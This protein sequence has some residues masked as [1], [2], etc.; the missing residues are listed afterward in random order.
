MRTL[1]VKNW[2]SF[3]HYKDRSPP[4]IRLYNALLDDYEFG[5]L[6]DASKWHLVAIW[7][8][9]SRSDN[10]IPYDAGW[11]SRR[12]NASKTVDLDALINSRF[13][14]VNQEEQ[15]SEHDASAPL[16]SCSPEQSR[17]EQSRGR[18][19]TGPAAIDPNWRP[20]AQTTTALLAEGFSASKLELSRT[21]MI[22]WAISNGKRKHDWDA[23]LRN[24][25]RRKPMETG[26][27]RQDRQ[28]RLA[29]AIEETRRDLG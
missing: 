20:S 26:P 9:A 15:S 25:V 21:E 4:W 10:R 28:S 18:K 7:L 14:I 22:D 11:V 2:E 24:W 12:I 19:K 29:A 8:L 3:Q 13:L 6:P 5:A 16:A 17:A 1:S 23:T 27:P